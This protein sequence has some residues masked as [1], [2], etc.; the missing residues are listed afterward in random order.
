MTDKAEFRYVVRCDLASCDR[1]AEFKVAAIWSDG[2]LTEL[3]PYGFACE[4]HVRELFKLAEERHRL[5]R[6][7]PG[8]SLGPLRV[9]RL[10]SGRRDSEL[11]VAEEVEAALKD[12]QG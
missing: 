4:R 6:L 9:Y 12:A 10:E 2:T 5:C 3:K 1:E 7:G 8:E 11:Q